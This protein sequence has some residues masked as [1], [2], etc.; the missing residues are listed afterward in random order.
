MAKYQQVEGVRK[1]CLN[2]YLSGDAA[3]LEYSQMT[4]SQLLHIW[5]RINP[6]NDNYLDTYEIMMFADHCFKLFENIMRANFFQRRQY[7]RS[8]PD[9]DQEDQDYDDEEH[10][11]PNQMD[12][13]QQPFFALN[14]ELVDVDA[15]NLDFDR[16]FGFRDEVGPRAWRKNLLNDVFD[17][18]NCKVED[19][20]SQDEDII[21]QHHLRL[22]QSFCDGEIDRSLIQ[23][24]KL[25]KEEYLKNWQ[26]FAETQ[27]SDVMEDILWSS[28]LTY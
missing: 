18:F 9:D 8:D 7:D 24:R 22:V 5:K 21:D 6:K 3:E 12:P 15:I 11:P 1:S 20:R 26:R 14:R 23:P 2:D 10:L 19:Q 28:S 4:A 27:F 25:F 16:K 17:K 13:D